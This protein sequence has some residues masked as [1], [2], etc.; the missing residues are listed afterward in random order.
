MIYQKIL[1]LFRSRAEA[2]TRVFFLLSQ[3]PFLLVSFFAAFQI[4]EIV[5]MKDDRVAYAPC[6]LVYYNHKPEYMFPKIVNHIIK[7]DNVVS[8]PVNHEETPPVS[9]I[10][11]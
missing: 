11:V 1:V 9:F 3:C 2:V 10:N 5:M 7:A 8:C 6:I 4:G